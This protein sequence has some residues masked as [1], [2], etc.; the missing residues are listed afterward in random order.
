MERTRLT[1]FITGAAGF[2]GTNLAI[3]YRDAGHKVISYDNYSTGKKERE[4]EGID[5]LDADVVNKDILDRVL[6][7]LRP[8]V[9]FHMAALARITPSFKK[10][11]DYFQTNANGTLNVVSWA[12]HNKVP[13]VYAGSSSHHSGKFKNPYT[14][15]NLLE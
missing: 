11:I 10:P 15:S 5:Y 13:V 4:Q 1:V 7:T 14:F 9:I 3:R 2:V 12:A 6:S 8:D